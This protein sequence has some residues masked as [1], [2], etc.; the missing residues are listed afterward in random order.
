MINLEGE[1]IFLFLFFIFLSIFKVILIQLYKIF[2]FLKKEE[3]FITYIY[4]RPSKIAEENS[5]TIFKLQK[6]L[7]ILYFTTNKYNNNML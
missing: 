7:H 3:K 4:K 1:K 5:D 6:S 2:K